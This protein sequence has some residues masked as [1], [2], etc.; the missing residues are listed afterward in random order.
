MCL[1]GFCFLF[2]GCFLKVDGFGAYGLVENLECYNGKHM[3]WGLGCF[4]A[5]PKS[6]LGCVCF[7]RVSGEVNWGLV[8]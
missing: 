2:E 5:F 6:G 7:W 1:F 8:F 3:V 4:V